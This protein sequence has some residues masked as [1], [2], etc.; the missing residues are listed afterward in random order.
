MKA[1]WDKWK[2]EIALV[3]G[4]FCISCVYGFIYEVLFYRINDGWWARRGTCYGPFIEIYGIGG[5]LIYFLCKGKNY[6]PWMVAFISGVGSGIVEYAAGWWLYTFGGHY[7]SWD[8]N[9]EIWNWGNINGFVCFRS[10]AVFAISGV[11]LM[12]VILPV[13][14]WLKK[15]IG[16]SVFFWIMFIP[17]IICFVDVFYNDII[18]TIFPTL[19][20]AMALWARL[21]WKTNY[22]G[23]PNFQ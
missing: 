1:F 10:V 16:A 12:F 15:K 11:L 19:D 17:G 8:Y 2:D 3:L 14:Q 5:I 23:R 21:G 13:L 4:I 18:C 6:K 22:H 20:N 9:K 7:R